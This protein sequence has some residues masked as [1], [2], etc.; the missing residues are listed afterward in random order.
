MRC[1]QNHEKKFNI[2]VIGNYGDRNAEI[3][4]LFQSFSNLTKTLTAAKSS[5]DEGD[6]NTALLNYHEAAQIFDT[7]HNIDKKGACMN[8]ISCLYIKNKDYVKGLNFINESIDI[9]KELDHVLMNDHTNSRDQYTK[10][11]FVTACRHFNKGLC[12][13]MNI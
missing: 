3:N 5:L 11:Q 13:F 6:D 8:N 4:F 10:H 1:N 12:C 2:N 9:S 7:L